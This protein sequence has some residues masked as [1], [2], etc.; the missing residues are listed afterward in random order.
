MMGAIPG[1]REPDPCSTGSGPSGFDPEREEDL[2]ALE[3]W[4]FNVMLECS[5][6]DDEQSPEVAIG[7]AV[8]NFRDLDRILTW[9]RG[10]ATKGDPDSRTGCADDDTPEPCHH[11]EGCG[12]PLYPE[13]YYAVDENGVA[14]CLA[15]MTD[16][17]AEGCPCYAHRVGKPDA[18]LASAIEA[19]RAETLQDGSVHGSATGEAPDA[20]DIHP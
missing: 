7:G 8:L 3:A 16:P 12:A 14:G 18:N 19:R 6:L 9:A 2:C 5:A 11:C 10:M 1:S 15:V 13:D 4:A 17:P 20:P